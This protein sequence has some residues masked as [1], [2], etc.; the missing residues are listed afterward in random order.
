MGLGKIQQGLIRAAFPENIA[1]GN[2]RAAMV[3]IILGANFPI[4]QMGL[5]HKK[6]SMFPH[7]FI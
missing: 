6:Y 1:A 4:V 2:I 7:V 3:G 5:N